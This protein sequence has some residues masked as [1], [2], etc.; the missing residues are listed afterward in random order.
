MYSRRIALAGIGA[1]ISLIFVTLAFYVR[2]ASVSFT[3]LAMVGI[4]LP[5]LQK[6]Y[7]EAVFAVIAVSGIA[8]IYT[9]LYVLPFALVSGSYTVVAVL[10]Y[11]KK[12]KRIIVYAVIAVYGSLVFFFLYN[13]AKV[14]LL[15][16]LAGLRLENLNEAQVYLAFNAVFVVALALFDFLVISLYKQIGNVI[17]KNGKE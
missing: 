11:E 15:P 5:L 17:L 1:S 9:G 14:L 16:N 6:Y 7:K 3:V 13:L 12:V 10:F 2:W 4:L 8:L